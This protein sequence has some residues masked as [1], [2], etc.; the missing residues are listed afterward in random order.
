MMNASG[1]AESSSRSTTMAS[2]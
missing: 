2:A 1:A